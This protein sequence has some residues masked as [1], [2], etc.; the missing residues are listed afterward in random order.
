MPPF[1]YQQQPDGPI[2]AELDQ[3]PSNGWSKLYSGFEQPSVVQR[4]QSLIEE[5]KQQQPVS[6]LERLQME[7]LS[8]LAAQQQ[9]NS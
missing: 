7:F 6:P 5:A 3:A 9:Q 2:S 8:R 1:N 4:Y